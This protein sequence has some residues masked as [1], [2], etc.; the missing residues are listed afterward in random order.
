MS[1]EE[2][3]ELD[4]YGLSRAELIRRGV[5]MNG[6]QQERHALNM[7]LLLAMQ[8]HDLAAQ[9]EIGRRMREVQEQIRCI[10]AAPPP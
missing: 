1:G 3:A 9:E 7:R 5:T 10:G 4:G 2:G 8:D 6:L